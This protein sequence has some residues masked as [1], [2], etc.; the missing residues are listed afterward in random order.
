MFSSTLE[1]PKADIGF[2]GGSGTF[3]LQFPEDLGWAG[4]E[5]LSTGLTCHTP[6]GESPPLKLFATGGRR[7]RTVL[8]A[9]MHGRIPGVP[10][11]EAS[12]RLFW[13]FREA[14]VQK[15]IA[16]GGVGSVNRLLDPRDIVIPDDYIDFSMRRDI[17]IGEE[18]LLVMRQPICPSLQRT[19]VDATAGSPLGRVFP[20][21][22]YLA[23][24]GRHFESPA[25][26]VHFRQ[27]GADVVGQ[28]LCPEVYLAREIGA[29]YAGIYLVANYG[30][31]TVKPWEYRLLKDIFF[32]DAAPFGRIV[33]RAL[34]AVELKADCECRS[35]RKPTLLRPE[36]VGL[37]RRGSDGA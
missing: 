13:V 36:N 33:M 23:T 9:K 4:A 2:I 28:S 1:V 34:E 31:G 10:W 6:F 21:G 24:D 8:A 15:V 37:K 27:W 25:E 12:R 7:P 35:L 18:Y 29:C 19:L 14:G 32:E 5:V 17:S 11:G 30:E 16:E 26:V 3:S 22:V 20:R